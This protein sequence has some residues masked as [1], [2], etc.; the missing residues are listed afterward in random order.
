[1]DLWTLGSFA[2]GLV[3]LV[4]G[5]SWLVRGASALALAMGISPLVIG[6]T[7][8]AFGTSAPELG[9]TLRAAWAGESD[10]A[11]GNVIGSNIANVLLILGASAAIA[12]LV[13]SRQVIRREVP[14]MVA[15]SVLVTVLALDGHIGR[16]DGTLLVLGVVV[17]VVVS[18]RSSRQHE[19]ARRA[20]AGGTQVRRVT[21]RLLDA[22]RA[23]AGLILLLVGT[24]GVVG[25]AT[26][27]ATAMGVSELMIGLTVVALGTSLPEGATSVVASLRGERDLAVGNAV[28][29]NIF[30][31]LAILGLTALVQ[32][33][34]VPASVLAFEL[35]LM[36]AVAVACL[37]VFVSGGQIARW[38][39]LVF[40][41]YYA[42]YVA[43]L[44][45]DATGHAALPAYHTMM[46]VFVAPLTAL[47]LAVIMARHM[48][49]R[50]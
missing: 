4:G 47:T 38:E 17:Y 50:R 43:Y 46:V 5:A 23:T 28:G 9:V 45:L 7:V 10:L 32:P 12:P 41:A 14:L 21:P 39:G 27:M 16:M 44:V 18:I 13:V 40:L 31:L 24:A 22:V 8:V 49:A 37:P 48:L 42:A 3:L 26:A 20:P 36:V 6:L 33:V 1:M 2:G 15:I 35:P 29:S 11:L 34:A 25:G 30:N 19:A